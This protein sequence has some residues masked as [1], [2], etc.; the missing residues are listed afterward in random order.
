[1]SAISFFKLKIKEEQRKRTILDNLSVQLKTLIIANTVCNRQKMWKYLFYNKVCLFK[2]WVRQEKGAQCNLKQYDTK[3]NISAFFMTQDRQH[4]NHNNFHHLHHHHTFVII[5]ILMICSRW[6]STAKQ[7]TF[8]IHPQTIEILFASACP[9]SQQ[10]NLMFP[11]SIIFFPFMIVI[12]EHNSAVNNC[13][14]RKKDDFIISFFTT[15]FNDR[16]TRLGLFD[17]FR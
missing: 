12:F 3:E 11:F 10:H 7:S 4:L 5:I 17:N 8:I 16:S 2:I 1:M 13:R 15:D 9:N 6:L 14:I